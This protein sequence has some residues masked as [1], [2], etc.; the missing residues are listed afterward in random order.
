MRNDLRSN[1]TLRAA[2]A[3]PTIRPLCVGTAALL[4]MTAAL[5]GAQAAPPGDPIVIESRVG[6]RPADADALLR[7]VLA[8]LSRSGF[9]GPPAVAARIDQVLSRASRALGDDEAAAAIAAIE[10]GYKQFVAGKFDAAIQ[11]IERGLSVLHAA[12]AAVIGQSGRRDIV[13]R[14][15]I[16]LALANKRRGRAAQAQAAMKELV[17]SFP[18]REVSYKTYGPEPREFFDAV[19]Q[20]LGADGKGSIAID[21]DDDRTAVFL[22]ERYVGGGDVKVADLYPGAYRVLLQQGNRTGRV[23]EVLV[24]PGATAAVSLSWQLDAALETAGGAGLVFDNEAAR[25]ELEARFAVRLARALGAPSVVVVGIRENRGSRSVVGAFHAAESTRPLRSGAIAVEPVVPGPERFEALARLLA[26]DDAAAALVVPLSD[27]VVRPAALPAEVEGPRPFRM[28]KWVTLTAGLAG[29]AAGATLIAVHEPEKPV[30]DERDDFRRNT[31]VPGI[32]TAAAGA[33]VTGVGIY[34]FA[35]DRRD[36]AAGVERAAVV[37]IEGGAV[38][39]VAGR[40]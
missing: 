28:W 22:N 27:E 16:G 1:S 5:N 29:M 32:V 7:P 2:F 36:R 26:G 33:A 25:R 18:D 4:V 11:E 21:L 20:D 23:H 24:E 15:L 38:L 34:F 17:R 35:R 6:A 10:A 13:M 3:E 9:A 8:E 39:V 30:V 19:R 12:P 31:L 14:G 40:F 37:P